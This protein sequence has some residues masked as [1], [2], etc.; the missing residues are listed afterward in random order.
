M[1]H[2]TTG[3][4]SGRVI[5]KLMADN[6]RL[7]RDLREQAT[8]AEELQRNMDNYKPRIDALQAEN[9]NLN[10]SQSVDSALLAR[11]DRMIAELKNELNS[12]KERRKALEAMGQR[13][14]SERDEAIEEKRRELQTAL[15]KMKHAETHAQILE[16]GHKQLSD[17]YQARVQSFR[18][19]VDVLEKER[20]EDRARL[21]KLDVVS[22]QMRQELERTKKLQAEM[23]DQ[24]ERLQQAQQQHVQELEEET[25]AENE[26]TRKLSAQM[27][28]VVNQ[29]KWVMGVK[30]NTHLDGSK[31]AGKKEDS[32]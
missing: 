13:L 5:E 18:T 21:A 12:E 2:A 30:Q 22:Q 27:D 1:G 24:W 8:K 10:H 3:G 14:T 25:Q 29:M 32:A 11:R 23:V 26:K 20:D 6:D 4:K 28:E 31:D 15:E 17:R 16:T 7:K 19:E 9:D